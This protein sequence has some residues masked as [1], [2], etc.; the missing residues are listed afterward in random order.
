MGKYFPSQGLST[1]YKD[2]YIVTVK[3]EE[4]VG[5]P[6]VYVFNTF[7]TIGGGQVG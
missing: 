4:V 2:L 3:L 6:G 7:N 1:N 5:H